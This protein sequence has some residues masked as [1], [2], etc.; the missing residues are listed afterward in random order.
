MV[1]GMS[2]TARSHLTPSLIASLTDLFMDAPAATA[3]STA[4]A[5]GDGLLVEL[6]GRTGARIAAHG[7]TGDA[8]LADAALVLGRMA[9]GTYA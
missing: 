9:D 2:N 3:M 8:L 7:K 4:I 6:T 5:V 1:L